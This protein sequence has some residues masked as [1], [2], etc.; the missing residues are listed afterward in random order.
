M[1]S[2]PDVNLIIV[3]IEKDRPSYTLHKITED[4]K[5]LE[6]IYITA[7]EKKWIQSKQMFFLIIK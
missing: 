3:F 7:I 2:I 4:M 1:T 6:D 5:K